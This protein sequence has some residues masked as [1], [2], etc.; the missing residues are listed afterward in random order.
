M[1]N[2]PT[3]ISQTQLVNSPHPGR[4]LPQYIAAL[5]GKFHFKSL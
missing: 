3:T 1:E 2:P 5:A 4:K